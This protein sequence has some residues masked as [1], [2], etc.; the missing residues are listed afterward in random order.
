[1]KRD[2]ILLIVCAVGMCFWLIYGLAGKFYTNS[3][4]NKYGAR[5]FKHQDND[6]S[7]G[8]SLRN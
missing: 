3:D 4:M 2:K 8:P 7:F 6:K 5:G 1:M